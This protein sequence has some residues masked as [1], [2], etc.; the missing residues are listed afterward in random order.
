MSKF[1]EML[2]SLADR[3][4]SNQLT[5]NNVQ[6]QVKE[7]DNAIG[8]EFYQK[9]RLI[10]FLE[11]KVK[12]LEKQSDLVAFKAI[13]LLVKKIKDR[14]PFFIDPFVD[15]AGE[16]A[17]VEI[18][19]LTDA[20]VES[21][22][23]LVEDGKDKIEDKLGID[24]DEKVDEVVDE[25]TIYF[26]PNSGNTHDTENSLNLSKQGQ[27]TLQNLREKHAEAEVPEDEEEGD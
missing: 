17:K 20:L 24:V 10:S 23:K 11:E 21:L 1:S 6:N 2:T 26:D 18:D 14:T 15:Q 12:T 25:S 5:K 7:I 13:D 3:I 4:F 27:E 19:K 16:I 9:D 8:H 22:V